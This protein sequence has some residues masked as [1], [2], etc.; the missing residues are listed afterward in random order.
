M[1]PK[2][3]EDLL[4]VSFIVMTVWTLN[5]V[6][7]FFLLSR[8]N[9][10][11]NVQLYNYGLQFN[12]QWAD[13][14]GSIMELLMIFTA[15]P[16]ALSIVIFALGVFVFRKK[17]LAF[18]LRRKSISIPVQ[19]AKEEKQNI[20]EV[21][22]K[23]GEIETESVISVTIESESEELEVKPELSEES[24]QEDVGLI[25][26]ELIKVEVCKSEPEVQKTDISEEPKAKESAGLVISCSNCG[27]VFSKPMVMLD[28]NKGTTRL[29]NVCPFCNQILDE[30]V[31][32]KKSDGETQE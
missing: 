12:S 22:K 21:G 19:E 31:E 13:P 10:I 30:T 24:Q 4:R 32:A 7:I 16:M 27:K 17:P 14:Y 6:L 26:P 23:E 15:L 18:L 11:V 9:S 20:E 29:L 2:T 1:S 8:L 5:G 28:F 3:W 25:Q